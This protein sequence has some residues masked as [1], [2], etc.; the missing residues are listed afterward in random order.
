[1]SEKIQQKK[2]KLIQKELSERLNETVVNYGQTMNETNLSRDR[3]R[4]N[5]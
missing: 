2:R 5:A 1:M 3:E 4:I